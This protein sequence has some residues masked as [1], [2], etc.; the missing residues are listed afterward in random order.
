MARKPRVHLTG[1]YYHVMMRGNI[2]NDLFYSEA[3]R[4]RFLFLLQEGIE[5]YGYRVHAFCLM[6]NHVHLL[7]QVGEIPLS[8][9][10]QNLGF[11]YTRYVNS[12]RQEV[13]HLFQ[14]RYKAILVE[15]DRY[16][17][18]LARYIHLNPVRAGLCEVASDFDW[19]SHN[20][21]MGET[22]VPWLFM[23]EILGHYSED[24]SR[25]RELLRYFT[26]E[27]A[28]EPRRAE[29]H[30]G[31]HQGQILGDDIFAKQVLNASGQTVDEKPPSLADIIDAVCREYQADRA[32]LDGEGNM[33]QGAEMRAMT[34]WVVQ[35]MEGLTLTSLANELRRDL[36]A[37]SRAA[38]RRQEILSGH[39]KC[40][41]VKPDPVTFGHIGYGQLRAA[42]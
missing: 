7:I 4:S 13:G 6:T 40:Q 41:T 22:E 23:R 37:L 33:R 27:G 34:A 36:S 32:V 8:R 3:D 20:A 15:A 28:G 10:I 39:S 21:Y 2:G 38:G 35:D 12:K 29:F 14:G 25:A 42:G 30:S 18:E 31:S 24:E 9:I 5:R 26:E 1:G 19:S 16:L 11:R 17:L